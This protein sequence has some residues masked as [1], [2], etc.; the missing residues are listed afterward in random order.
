MAPGLVGASDRHKRYGSAHQERPADHQKR[1]RADQRRPLPPK[2]Y[3]RPFISLTDAR[4]PRG[5]T[6][7]ES[8]LPRRPTPGPDLDSPAQ[9]PPPSDLRRE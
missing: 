2:M 6:D 9:N 3:D 8:R 4:G 5:P 7:S 1:Q